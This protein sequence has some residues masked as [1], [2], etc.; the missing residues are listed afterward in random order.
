[1]RDFD[2]LFVAASDDV[3]GGFVEFLGVGGESFVLC[4]GCYQVV[5]LRVSVR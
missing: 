1:M 5:G 4:P 3:F 2:R